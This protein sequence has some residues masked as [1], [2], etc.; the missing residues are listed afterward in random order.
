M[1]R[2]LLGILAVAVVLGVGL[3]VWMLKP[4]EGPARDLTLVG[5]AT[6][7]AYLMRLGGCVACHTD[8]ADGRAMLAGGRRCRRSS[9]PS[10]PPTSRPIRPPASATG[11]WRSFRKR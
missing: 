4:V 3:A 10:M 1:R 6:R 2:W 11:R 7:G 9:A 8:A 5:D